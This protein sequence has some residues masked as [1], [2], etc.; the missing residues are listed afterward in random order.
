MDADI[1]RRQLSSI[2]LCS[3]LSPAVRT[4]P[5]LVVPQAGEHAWLSVLLAAPLLLALFVLVDKLLRSMCPCLSPPRLIVRTLGL[6]GRLLLLALAV[7]MLF[8]AAFTM[9]SAANRFISTIF[10]ESKPLSYIPA[11]GLLALMTGLGRFRVLGRT[12]EIIKPLL[13]GVMLLTLLLA[14]PGVSVGSYS[15]PVASELPGIALGALPVLNAV[16]VGL[17]ICLCGEGRRSPM[18]SGTLSLCTGL[19]ALLCFTAVGCFGAALTL[20]IN[21][22]YFV[23][24]RNLRMFDAIERVEALVIALWFFTDFVLVA[25]LIHASAD[26][27]AEV[28]N[29]GIDRPRGFTIKLGGGRWLVWLCAVASTVTAALIAPTTAQLAALSTRTIPWLNSVAALLL[30]P[31]VLAACALKNKMSAKKPGA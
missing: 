21:N 19:I 29:I 3:V 15:R 12:A 17:Y 1:N 9:R 27:L 7:W 30:L 22:P 26:T 23:M 10:P 2:A 18:G 24:V 20:Q 16:S 28:L 8:Y 4:L 25:L 14:L 5:A 6:P 11:M 31:A 13:V